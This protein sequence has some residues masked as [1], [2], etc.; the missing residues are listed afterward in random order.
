[1]QKFSVKPGSRYPFGATLDANG[2][3]FSFFSRHANGAELLL[4]EHVDSAEP[5]QMRARC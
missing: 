2:V 4:F 3:N 5:F 1:V